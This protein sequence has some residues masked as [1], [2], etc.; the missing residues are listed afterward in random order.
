MVVIVAFANVKCARDAGCYHSLV[1]PGIRHL[2]TYFLFPFSVDKEAVLE[3]HPGFWPNRRTW[4]DG[5]DYWIDHPL[6]ERKKP[7][8]AELLGQWRRA[9]YTKFGLESEAYQTMVFFHP[10]VR[11]VFFDAHEPRETRSRSHEDSLL[12]CYEIDLEGKKTIFRGEDQEGR[13]A[14]VEVTDLRLFL[15][16]NGIGVLSLGVET[17]DTD[18]REALWINEMMR[19]VYPS[20]AR[21]IRENRVPS[22]LTL[23]VRDEDRGDIPVIEEKF[24]RGGLKH[25]H[26][27][28]SNTITELLYFADYNKHEY[29]AVLDERMI[30]YTYAA[31]DKASVPEDYLSSEAFRILLSRFLYVDRYADTYRYDRKFTRKLLQRQ[32]YTRWSHQGTYYGFTSY[33]SVTLTCGAFDCDDHK[34]REG[35][36]IHRMFDTRYYL[37]ALIALFYR[38]TLLDF[39]E[40]A[41]LVS[42]RLYLDQADGQLTADSI[43]GAN[44]L[45]ADF[46][47]FTNYWLFDELANKDEEMEHF[48]LQWRAYR[49]AIMRKQTEEEIEK[50]NASLYEFYQ[51]QN[52]LAVN[53]L[54]V[55]SMVLGA[56]AV[57][58]GYF[59]MN[60]GRGFAD[61]FFNAAHPWTWLHWIAIMAVSAFA[62]AALVF[63]AYLILANW[64][65]YRHILVPGRLLHE[66]ESQSLRRSGVPIVQPARKK[67]R[68]IVRKKD[69]DMM[70]AQ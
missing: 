51:N 16:A 57:L 26:P 60:F 58:T 19:K 46:L 9:A 52:A 17:F 69:G 47:H 67:R 18:A 42:K 21:Q 40:R 2:H 70:K 45:R 10:F 68:W 6:N 36:L 65:D 49:L 62:I 15:F 59:G 4:F 34:L 33:S 44:R 24:G 27:R 37:M 8:V 12:N 7:K 50:L 30:V 25:F 55:S 29:A 39:A 53:R 3:D 43:Q 41:A 61:A 54:A 31:I 1:A 5:L 63:A 66:P 56:G 38:A 11:R 64:R 48:L 35:F 20:S 23:L 28:L 14:E 13:A 32:L 22:R